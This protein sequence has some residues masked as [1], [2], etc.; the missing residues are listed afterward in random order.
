MIAVLSTQ[1]NSTT[2]Q[3]ANFLSH[4]IFCI[5]EK[6]SLAFNNR[7]EPVL[8]E[9]ETYIIIRKLAHTFEYFLLGLA[10]AYWISHC[11]FFNNKTIWAFVFCVSVSVVDQFSKTLIPGR[12]FDI[13]DFP[14]DF[15]GYIIGIL[16]TNC[17][18]NE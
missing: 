7:K 1:S 6:I 2:S 8:T 13:T 4:I 5:N 9:Y 10:I 14:F 3:E 15:M 12:E 17:L 11:G 16:L 18:R